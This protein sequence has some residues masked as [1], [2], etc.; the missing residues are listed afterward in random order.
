MLNAGEQD[1]FVLK[2][3]RDQKIGLYT[4]HYKQ[5]YQWI[6]VD[7]GIFILQFKNGKLK[8]ANGHYI[9]TEG[10]DPFPKLTPDDAAKSYA[11]YLQIPDV[12]ALKFLHD[13][14]IVEIETISGTDTAYNANLCYKIDLLNSP[15]SMGETGY[16]DAQSGKILKI[17]KNWFNSS[18]TGTFAT[19]YSGAK[20]AGTQYYGGVYNLIDSSRNAIINTWDLN[21][22][23]ST[24]YSDTSIVD[25]FT[26]N[27]NN[28]TQQEHSPTN[29]QMA[30]DI[31]WAL[32]EIYDYF[33]V[34]H[35]LQSF[36]DSN[37][38]IDAFVHCYLPDG[39]SW[40]KDN[41][42]FVQFVNGDQVF[43]FGDGQTIFKPIGALDAVTHEF[44]HAI[45]HNHTGWANLTTVRR[46]LHEGFSDIWG[47]VVENEVAPE[48]DHWKIGE[49]VIDVTGDDCL[50]NIRDPESSTSYTQIADCFGDTRYNDGG[51]DEAYEKSGVLSH[52]F[53]LLSEGDSGINDNNDE[54]TVYG[55]GIDVAAE[56]VFDGQTSEFASVSSYADARDAMIDAADDIFGANS[57]QSLQVANAWYAVG[58]GTNPTQPTI[59]GPSVVYYSG[60]TFTANNPPNGSNIK[61][62]TSSNLSIQTGETTTTPTIRAKYSSSQGEGWVQVNFFSNGYET[63]GPRYPVWVGT[64]DPVEIDVINVGPYYPGSMILCSDMPNDGKV[65]WGST[66]SIQEYSWSVYDDGNNYWQV[67]QHPMD[68][69][70]AIPMQDVQFSKPYGSVNGYV[71]VIVKARNTCGWGAYSAPAKQFS[72]TTCSGYFLFF[73]PNPTSGETTLS[74]E[75]NSSEKTF[76]ETAQWDLEVYLETQ[77]L[78]TKQTGLRGQSAK[79]QTAGWKE[80]VYLVRVKYNDEIL[81]G[82]LVVKR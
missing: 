21:N 14:V 51:N 60:S 67:I 46:A 40:T 4:E 2:N 18:A 48:K 11:S 47:A 77:L 62:E 35:S 7:G 16:V 6:E 15:S 36:N 79:I 13:L 20:N 1:Q 57:F 53:Y 73:T 9:D 76:D 49:E 26:D 3:K 71:N 39:V 17:Q 75:T 80:G 54:Y 38:M 56:I 22:A 59:S 25:E 43:F 66:G 74:I 61:W 78:K 52:W 28:W 82:K 44:S 34:E 42:A 50:R 58:V 12:S 64:P 19:L 32:Q 69:F 81:T 70:P 27:D 72:T 30:L 55:L 45:T 31:H 68:P 24:S 29:D 41:A 10:I 33:N 8:K 63:P 5:F 23:Y 37:H 65:D